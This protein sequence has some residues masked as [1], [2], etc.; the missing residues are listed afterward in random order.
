MSDD[1]SV[2]KGQLTQWA[3]SLLRINHHGVVIQRELKAGNVEQAADLAERARL[4]AWKILNELFECGAER[5]EE[6]REAGT[7][8][9]SADDEGKLSKESGA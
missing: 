3:E 2:T 5:P 1:F 7:G 4:R 6:Y 9:D 8:S